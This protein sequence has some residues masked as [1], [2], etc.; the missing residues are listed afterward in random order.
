[1]EPLVFADAALNSSVQPGALKSELQVNYRI[2]RAGIDTLNL[3]IPSAHEVLTVTGDDIR[4]WTL[5]AG[6]GGKNRLVVSLHDA[7]RDQYALGVSLEAAL[8]QLP[9]EIGVPSVEVLGAIRQR[10]SVSLQAANE[11]EVT[12]SG[13]SGL[14]QQAGGGGKPEA[15]V[16][17]LGDFRYLRFPYA[18]QLGIKAA[19]PQGGGGQ[20]HP[21]QGHAR[22]GPLHF[23]ARFHGEA[24][25]G[26]S[27]PGSPCRRDTRESRPTGDVV[28]DFREIPGEDGAAP[29]L[30]IRFKQRQSG[31]F[32][33][34]LSGRRVRGDAEEALEVPALYPQDVARHDGKVGLDVHT[35]LEP[36]TAEAG[37]FR[38]ED[39]ATLAGEL[40]GQSDSLTPLTLGFRYRGEAAP[41]S[42]SF[43]LKQSQV[44][45]DV[46]AL[47][48]VREQVVR[49]RWTL[50]LDILYSGIDSF[51]LGVPEGIADD[52]R[53]EDASVKEI[54]KDYQPEE[55]EAADLPEGHVIWRIVLRDKK[56][57][58]LRDRTDLGSARPSNSMPGRPLPV[59]MPQ[60]RLLDVFRETGQVA[61][62][63]EANLEI[64]DARTGKPGTD[65]SP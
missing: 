12:P 46:L 41:A 52:L 36:N 18:V 19:E 58:G 65:R 1:M 29:V 51:L 61:V 62:I 56:N 54:E 43:K 10:G 64:Q 27:T 47:V 3:E 23:E 63:K 38:G 9:V 48:E 15:A 31:A 21:N 11:L 37:D 42:L 24:G 8:E 50:G 53:L 17:N 39:V 26:F 55:G 22:R 35:S 40:G 49:Y 20:L 33:V 44:N 25:S 6:E 59:K 4:E 14:S 2:L 57:G 45:A 30:E 5:E 60:L 16:T 32:A 7:A 13:L 28:E 34:N